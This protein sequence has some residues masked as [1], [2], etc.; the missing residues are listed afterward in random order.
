MSSLARSQRQHGCAARLRDRLEEGN[1][2]TAALEITSSVGSGAGAGAS[3]GMSVGVGVGVGESNAGDVERFERA[4]AHYLLE[5][6]SGSGAG[7]AVFDFIEAALGGM[8]LGHGGTSSTSLSSPSSAIAAEGRGGRAGGNDAASGQSV[9]GES[10][11]A[12]SG[13]FAEAARLVA[14]SCALLAE[15]DLA[16][17]LAL[18]NRFLVGDGEGE[19]AA[20]AGAGAWG[21]TSEIIASTA[22]NPPL[23]L[24]IL[25]SIVAHAQQCGRP[26]ADT[27]SPQDVSAF[28]HLLA[29]FSPHRLYPF[30]LAHPSAAVDGCLPLCLERGI[31]DAAA[32]LLERQGDLHGALSA[33]LLEWSAQTARARAGVEV[34]L[35]EKS[36]CVGARVR[37]C[38]CVLMIERVVTGIRKTYLPITHH[39][40]FHSASPVMDILSKQGNHPPELTHAFTRRYLTTSLS[41]V[42]PFD[43]LLNHPLGNARADAVRGLPSF[44]GLQHLTQCA[45]GLCCRA[46][47]EGQEEGGASVSGSGSGSGGSGSSG[48]GGGVGMAGVARELWLRSLD[49]FLEEKRKFESFFLPFPLHPYIPK[50]LF[51]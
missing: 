7:S 4:L 38:M 44:P 22:H 49:H 47:A 45:I 30:L 46:A 21:M 18:I 35:R 39:Y 20:G 41:H 8:R 1:F 9:P 33:L 42:I 40:T 26:L 17:C 13:A 25:S 37:V 2:W 50:L 12:R 31:V 10:V 14:A 5:A 24:D 6:G 3:A 15:L 19:G 36:R 43:R 28:L 34:L 27:L 23:Q 16:R 51:F 29:R 48:T 32:L 11:S